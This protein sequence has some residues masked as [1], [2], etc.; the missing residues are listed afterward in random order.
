[1]VGVNL[2][3]ANLVNLVGANLNGAAAGAVIGGTMGAMKA[4][5]AR[6]QQAREAEAKKFQAIAGIEK[7]KGLMIN[8]ALTSMATAFGNTLRQNQMI[9]RF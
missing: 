9:G 5:A 1:M 4:S 3:G 2:A 8:N 6:K 7:T